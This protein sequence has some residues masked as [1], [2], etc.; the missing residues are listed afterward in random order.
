MKRENKIT[1][2]LVL[3]NHPQI[4]YKITGLISRRGF[5]ITSFKYNSSDN[6]EFSIITFNLKNEKRID[7]LIKQFQNIYEVTKIKIM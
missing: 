4:L 7:F 3:K 5:I 2:R 6:S 1:I